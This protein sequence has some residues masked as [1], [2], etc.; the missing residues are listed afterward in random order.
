[1]KKNFKGLHFANIYLVLYWWYENTLAKSYQE[2][3][4]SF[5][6]TWFMRWAQPHGTQKHTST[7]DS[8]QGFR[9]KRWP[10]NP[11]LWPWKDRGPEYPQCDKL[12][13]EE[14]LCG[15][16]KLFCCFKVTLAL[17]TKKT[18]KK[19]N[20][21]YCV[22][23]SK[24]TSFFRSLL[25]LGISL[26]VCPVV[27]VGRFQHKKGHCVICVIKANH[28]NKYQNCTNDFWELLVRLAFCNLFERH[29]MK[30]Q[31]T[32]KYGLWLKYII[33]NLFLAYVIT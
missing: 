19:Q 4:N 28:V 9:R 15:W 29:E 12:A 26:E 18:I 32:E 21:A 11:C 1:M 22:S 5:E 27:C 24:P 7:Q 10:N 31:P 23:T 2:P 14:K 8:P 13:R 3:Q 33:M 6:I 17:L 16:G 30:W 25:R 20:I